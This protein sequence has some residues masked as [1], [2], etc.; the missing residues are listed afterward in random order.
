MLPK[1]PCRVKILCTLHGCCNMVRNATSRALSSIG[2][3][4]FL[5]KYQGGAIHN[6]VDYQI[7]HSLKLELIVGSAGDNESMSLNFEMTIHYQK[8]ICV[9]FKR[10]FK[11]QTFTSQKR[12]LQSAS[13]LLKVEVNLAFVCQKHLLNRIVKLHQLKKVRLKMF[14]ISNLK[15]SKTIV[16]IGP[17]N[18][19]DWCQTFFL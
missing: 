15:V 9:E 17:E 5:H 1:F 12:S 4:V 13:C 6:N 16:V 19:G 11:K 8:Y 2:M 14:G 10:I 18:E 7:Y 3:A